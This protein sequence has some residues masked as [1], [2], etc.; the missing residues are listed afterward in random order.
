MASMNRLAKEMRAQTL[1]LLCEGMS[2]RAATRLTG[3]SQ[4]TVTK[5]LGD[6]GK[7]VAWYQDH[8]FQNLECKRV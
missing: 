3:T 2:I 7:A 1:H 5:L 6:A 4:T 8:V